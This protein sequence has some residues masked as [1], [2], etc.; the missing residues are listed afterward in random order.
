ML[1]IN[2]LTEAG[3]IKVMVLRQNEVSI[4]LRD[5]TRHLF[6]RNNQKEVE[7]AKA[8]TNTNQG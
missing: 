3:N 6:L 7:N 1:V 4:T 2:K 5:G 8:N